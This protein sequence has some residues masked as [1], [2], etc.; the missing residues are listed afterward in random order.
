[1]SKKLESKFSIQLR[2]SACWGFYPNAIE[3]L[4]LGYHD[5]WVLSTNLRSGKEGVRTV[6]VRGIAISVLGE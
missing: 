6:A 4:E 2:I 1:M 5:G 3:L